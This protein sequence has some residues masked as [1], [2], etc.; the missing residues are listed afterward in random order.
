MLFARYG[1]GV[2]RGDTT[3][4]WSHV[5][6]IRDL[7]YAMPKNIQEHA[8]LLYQTWQENNGQISAVNDVAYK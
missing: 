8:L 6:S 1:D 4:G 5:L 3:K 2:S 7:S